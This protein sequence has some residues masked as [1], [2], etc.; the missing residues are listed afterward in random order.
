MIHSVD[1]L[2]VVEQAA[3]IRALDCRSGVAGHPAY[4]ASAIRGTLAGVYAGQRVQTP[5]Q[6]A[7]GFRLVVRGTAIDREGGGRA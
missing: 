1:A 7:A 3:P 6:W 5:A 4:Q 2:L